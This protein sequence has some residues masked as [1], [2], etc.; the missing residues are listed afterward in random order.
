MSRYYDAEIGRFI[1]A[2]GVIDN[3][4]TISHNLFVYCMNNPIIYRD[5]AGAWT[6]GISI[7]ANLTLFL[8]VSIGIG[9]YWDDNGNFEI[10]WSYTCPGVDNTIGT[11]VADVGVGG[12]FQVTKVDTVYDL[13]GI[14]TSVG[15]S[16]G[17]GWYVGGDVITLNTAADIDAEINGF[18]ITGG[19]GAGLDIHVNQTNTKPLQRQKIKNGSAAFQNSVIYKKYSLMEKRLSV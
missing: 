11:G 18:Q 17:S 2:D 3:R 12:T 1:N 13:H 15:V 14:I 8:G 5:L 16:G 19:F 9:M 7:G 6:V 10:Q 4:K